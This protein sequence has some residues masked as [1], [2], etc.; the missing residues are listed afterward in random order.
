MALRI[1]RS[2]SCRRGNGTRFCVSGP[3]PDGLTIEL[4]NPDDYYAVDLEECGTAAEALSWVLHAGARY[5]PE[6][7][8]HLV[9]A[10]IELSDPKFEE[11]MNPDRPNEPGFDWK[12]HLTQVHPRTAP[13]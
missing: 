7:A 1:P 6:V 5:G 2:D 10:L 9:E 12:R 3:F 11:A 13:R 8:G 4:R